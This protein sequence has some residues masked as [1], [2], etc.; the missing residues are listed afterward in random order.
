MKQNLHPEV[1]EVTAQCACG[2]SFPT[3]STANDLRATI[4]SKCHPFFTG[5]QKFVDV[6]GRIEKFEA[7]Y[8]KFQQGAATPAAKKEA[9]PAKKK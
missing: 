9:K 7:R 5:A 3:I 8:K 4:C 2:N 1:H 6:A